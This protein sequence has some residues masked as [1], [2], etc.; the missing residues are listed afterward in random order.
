M[1]ASC[2]SGDR[3]YGVAEFDRGALL[4]PEAHLEASLQDVSLQDVAATIISE[5]RVGGPLQSPVS[6]E[7]PF[8]KS[9]IQEQRTYSVRAAVYDGETLLLTTDTMANAFPDSG[10]N[11]IFLSL[12]PVGDFNAR[13]IAE[14]PLG[15]PATFEGTLPCADCPGIRTR[16]SL[17]PNA[18]FSL[19]SEYLDRQ[20]AGNESKF[21]RWSY[22]QSNETVTLVTANKRARYFRVIDAETLRMLN[23]LGEE[24]ASSLNYEL[25]KINE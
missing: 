1:G 11:K 12:V 23:S 15:L 16:L 2:T 7:I 14:I 24:I 13:V 25:R 5:I 3:V 19:A 22:D 9:E 6:F 4:P 8:N 18:T 21:G 17:N 10:D 20:Y